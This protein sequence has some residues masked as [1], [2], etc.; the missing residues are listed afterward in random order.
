MKG[1]ATVAVCVTALLISSEWV[2][3]KRANDMEVHA[4]E[5][6]RIGLEAFTKGL[7]FKTTEEQK[8]SVEIR[9]H[10]RIAPKAKQK[11]TPL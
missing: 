4:L 7:R 6:E 3:T 2:L 10:F 11:G 8:P 5:E 9:P 1:L